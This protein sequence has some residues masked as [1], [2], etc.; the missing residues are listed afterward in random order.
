MASLADYFDKVTYKATYEIGDRVLGR[1]NG[2]P[3]IGTIGNDNQLNPIDGPFCTVHLDLPI[4]FEDA[5]KD[6]IIVKH[7][8]IN[9]LKEFALDAH[10][11]RAEDSKPSRSGFDSHV[12]HQKSKK[13]EKVVSKTE[14]L[15]GRLKA[16]K[17]KK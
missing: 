4:K 7:E 17:G 15:L 9:R 5:V 14:S 1:W 16:L 3:F 12:A 10:K 8:Q 13:T 2:I 6:V 11:G